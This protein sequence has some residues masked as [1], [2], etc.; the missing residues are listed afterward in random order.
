MP[1]RARGDKRKTQPVEESS[2]I[3]KRRGSRSEST[4]S[5]KQQK[6]IE[7]VFS[8]AP[9]KKRP[10]RSKASSP[11]KEEEE[12]KVTSSKAS[13]S[14]A[15]EEKDD[16][17]VK[18]FDRMLEW[19]TKL[20]SKLGGSPNFP[21]SAPSFTKKITRREYVEQYSDYEFAYLQII[22][23]KAIHLNSAKIQELNNGSATKHKKG[24]INSC[25]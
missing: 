20:K 13:N 19:L 12:V 22:G 7:D 4:S 8:P 10:S 21:R 15:S 6:K 9:E 18:E 2:P 23:F 16:L 14:A 24:D 11:K 3:A 17:D 5:K 1:P 25:F